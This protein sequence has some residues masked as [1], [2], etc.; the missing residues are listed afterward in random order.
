M[1]ELEKHTNQLFKSIE[2]LIEESKK[3]VAVLVNAELSLLYWN[4]GKQIRAEILQDQR[5]EY[6]KNIIKNLSSKLLINYGKGWS[7][8]HLHHCVKFSEVYTEPQIVH[9]L[10]TQLSWSHI[11]L[12]IS[13]EVSEIE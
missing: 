13:W 8:R 3:R 1:K 6:G 9:T 11:R 10:C 7:I 5:A 12:L 4:I 2:Q